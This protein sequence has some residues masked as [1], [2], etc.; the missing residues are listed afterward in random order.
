MNLEV[1]VYVTIGSIIGVSLLYWVLPI[2]TGAKFQGF[3]ALLSA[4]GVI[5]FAFSFLLAFLMLKGVGRKIMPL[6]LQKLP[7]IIGY[8]LSGCFCV[9]LS[10][11]PFIER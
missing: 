5:V 7:K 10:L 3:V 1:F 8:Y 2:N 4:L 11:T 9:S 6:H